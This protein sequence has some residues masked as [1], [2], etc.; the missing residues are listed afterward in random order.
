MLK[1]FSYFLQETV[2]DYF[3]QIVPN[4]DNLYEMS[5]LLLLWSA[6][7]AQR[8]VKFEKVKMSMH[9]YNHYNN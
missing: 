6:E 8:V 4:G 3:M 5:I 1:Y 9:F 2:F 7:L